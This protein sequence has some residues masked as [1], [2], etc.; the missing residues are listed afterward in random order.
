MAVGG[1]IRSV[2]IEIKFPRDPSQL[3]L[4]SQS[5][6]GLAMGVMHC[7]PAQPELLHLYNG[8][9]MFTYQGYV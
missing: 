6:T 7:P 5:K 9:R 8:G 1:N 3:A 4:Q 2:D